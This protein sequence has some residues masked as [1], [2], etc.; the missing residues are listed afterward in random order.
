MA[1]T[2]ALSVPVPVAFVDLTHTGQV[3]DANN[4]PLGIAYIAAAAI[5]TFGDRIDTGL[6]KYPD[7]FNAYLLT[8]TPQVAAFSNYMWNERLELTYAA[9]IKQ[10]HPGTVTIFGG[11]NF[12]ID[13]GEQAAWLRKNSQV[14]F[15]VDGEGETPFI[16]LMEALFAADFDIVA[17]K[18]SR[19]AVP[20]LR[21][22]DGDEFVSTAMAPRLMQLDESV[23]SPYLMGLMDQFFDGKLT[24]MMQTS[25]GC[26]YSCTFCHDGIAY[27]TKTM[28]FSQERIDA[29]LQYVFERATLPQLT[30]AD[31]N[32]GMFPQ[33]I[34][35]AKTL[36]SMR[37]SEKRWPS[38][39]IT[40]TAKMQKKRVIE[41]TRVL[42]D[43]M[44]IGAS[45]QSTDADVLTNIK[46]SNIS[47]DAIVEMAKESKQ[48]S[49]PSFTE[50][51]LALPGDTK[52]KHFKSLF[53]MADAGIE[54]IRS[55]QL[56]LLPGTEANSPSSRTTY[57]YETRF[58]VLPRCFGYYTVYDEIVPIAETHE[59][60]VGNSTMPHED[61]V[62]CRVIDLA[63]QIF[64]NGGLLEELLKLMDALGVKRSGVLRA[65]YELAVAPDS[66]MRSVFDE[67]RADEERNFWSERSELMAFLASPG[68]FDSYLTG[69]YGA[70]QIYKYR[71]SAVVGM[72]E[73]IVDIAI[74]A[75]RDVLAG[76][77]ADDP[78]IG[79]YL[80]ELRDVIVARRSALT[81][82]DRR[83]E[84]EVSFDFLELDRNNFLADP[85][86]VWNATPR[87][88]TIAHGDAR[89][90][91]LESYFSQYG[92]S[93]E[94][95]VYF[96]HRNPVQVLYRQFVEERTAVPA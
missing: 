93:Q 31:L 6:F 29:E 89:R 27:S 68:G 75:A 5:T 95:L 21:Y 39:V 4:F 36:A 34:E 45:I 56:V 33:D 80:L 63:I 44:W 40:A 62:E 70:N 65:I 43:A 32:W 69:E 54:D 3:I 61:Y 72:I 94:G 64:N 50:I 85:R 19:P 22:L 77:I 35:T 92:K 15:Y 38:S 26:P 79:Q 96:V 66:P 67:F 55:F 57:A 16:A 13:A 84:L 48:T 30:L 20:N 53:D 9:A 58:R 11:P 46:R 74:A 87:R 37:A 91:D 1:L 8:T 41:M 88:L 59:V 71:V 28:R 18:K 2:S 10:R 25:R 78:R 51:I 17:L 86:S 60:C 23:P 42:G 12:S 81:E 47:F 14:D 49:T 24:P 82:L 7:D 90:A 73:Q 83:F 52:E 76:H